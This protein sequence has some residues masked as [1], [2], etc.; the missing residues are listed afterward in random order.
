MDHDSTESSG[1]TAVHACFE[2]LSEGLEADAVARFAP[3]IVAE[4]RGLLGLSAELASVAAAAASDGI[5]PGAVLG[6][7]TVVRQIG[8]GGLGRVFEAVEH[9]VG[10]HVA[11]KVMPASWRADDRPLRPAE[12]RLLAQ[13][14]H[15][16]IARLYRADVTELNGRRWFW[17]AMELV[18]DAR[19]LTEWAAQDGRSRAA[20][21]GALASVAEA[22]Q[23]AHGRGVIH[24][25]L[26]PANVLVDRDDR[27]VVIDFGIAGMTEQAPAVTTV[28]L[29]TRL[30]GTLGYVAPEALEPGHVPDVRADLFALGAMLFELMA[31]EPLRRLAGATLAQQVHAVG[32]PVS[33]ALPQLT[34]LERRELERIIRRATAHDPADRYQTAAQFAD[35][36][37]R[38]L[39]GEPVLMQE[40]GVI[41]RWRRALW[42]NR[43]PVGIGTAVSLALL[44][45][46][47]VAL[48]QARRARHESRLARLSLASR[49]IAD[50]DRLVIER[51]VGS[52]QD[53][54]P[55]F[56]RDVLQRMLRVGQAGVV[57]MTCL[58]WDVVHGVGMGIFEHASAPMHGPMLAQVVDGHVTW[59]MPIVSAEVGALALS[60]DRCRALVCTQGGHVAWH[61]FPIGKATALPPGSGNAECNQGSIAQTGSGHLVC[62]GTTVHVIE[63][64]VEDVSWSLEPNL[65]LIRD[66][67]ASPSDPSLV[68]LGAEEGVLLLDVVSRAVRTL[69]ERGERA[70]A[71]A[72]SLNG[73]VALAA[74]RA[75]TAFDASTGVRMWT[76]QGHQSGVWGVVAL[77]HGRCATASADGS[78]RVWSMKDGTGLGALPLSSDRLWSLST[79]GDVLSTGGSRGAYTISHRELC[80]WFGTDAGSLAFDVQPGVGSVDAAERDQVRISTRHDPARIVSVPGIGVVMRS[81]IGP[82]GD[83]IGLAGDSGAVIL[84]HADGSPIWTD[85]G[86]ASPGDIHEPQGFRAIDIGPGHGHVLLGARQFGA[87]CLDRQDGRER[88]VT[89]LPSECESVAWSHDG[90]HAFLV[91]REGQLVKLD[92]SDG[93]VLQAVQPFKQGAGCV[94]VSRDGSRVLA[95][96]GEGALVIFDATNLEELVR[97]PAMQRVIEHLWLDDDGVHLVDGGGRHVVR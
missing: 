91:T 77:D 15:P 53:E 76:A 37:R 84:L 51:V 47:F 82:K 12:A 54:P 93:R 63:P 24:R 41:E 10:R 8:E 90:R 34:G 85:R 32:R 28:L 4:A 9:G 67:A 33:V 40:Q 58:D 48:S 89:R 86:H 17:M 3:S 31:G 66:L 13:L 57:P 79:D 65:G 78:I 5:G 21:I 60:H 29:G 62:A 87:V 6:E 74:S 11:V 73:R 83:V 59:S 50:A 1:L 68:L 18:R 75:L 45:L 2:L 56:E 94:A 26:K 14:E 46:A 97:I 70:R 7:F 80:E 43:L 72:W 95:G 19:T 92:G 35:D 71:V 23:H 81:S 38:H 20:C 44:V 22:V 25:D 88:W 96:S 64:G 27:A 36:L 39:R 49:A 52:L 30:E 55:T 69:G 16:G 61:E 42:R